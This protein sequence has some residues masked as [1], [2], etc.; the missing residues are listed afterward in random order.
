MGGRPGGA[1][2]DGAVEKALLSRALQLWSVFVILDASEPEPSVS[3]P[4]SGN[5]GGCCELTTQH[6]EESFSGLGWGQT[7]MGSPAFLLLLLSP[8][9]DHPVTGEDPPPATP[10]LR[11]C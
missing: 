4:M 7:E 5:G 3:M 8:L 11:Q 6:V 9:G 10:D 1:D 2:I